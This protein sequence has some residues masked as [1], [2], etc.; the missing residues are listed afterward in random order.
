[1]E[2]PETNLPGHHLRRALLW[3][4]RG[5]RP[6]PVTRWLRKHLAGRR[7]S[8]RGRRNF[9]RAWYDGETELR[10]VVTTWLPLP[11]GARLEDHAVARARHIFATRDDI[12]RELA[13][14]R[15]VRLLT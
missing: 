9:V 15:T 11:V 6:H 5:F 8:R 13:A 3:M 2:D 14:L 1:M 7:I 12:S 10:D 4:C